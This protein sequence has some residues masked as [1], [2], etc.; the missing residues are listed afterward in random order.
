MED[1]SGRAGLA[2]AAAGMVWV[3]ARRIANNVALHQ[4]RQTR[5]ACLVRPRCAAGPVCSD[6][7]VGLLQHPGRAGKAAQH[8][9]LPA[10]KPGDGVADCLDKCGGDQP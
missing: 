6:A 10:V 2:V 1:R 7:S 8:V 9:H 3:C 5:A 4:R